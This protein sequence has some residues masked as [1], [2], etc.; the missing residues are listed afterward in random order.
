MEMKVSM[1][2]LFPIPT[3]YEIYNPKILAGNAYSA[4][5]TLKNYLKKLTEQKK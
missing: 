3:K 5:R 4:A 1:E 2:Y